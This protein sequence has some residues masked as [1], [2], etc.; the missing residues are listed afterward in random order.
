M[1]VGVLRPNQADKKRIGPPTGGPELTDFAADY[2]ACM[3]LWTMN[4]TSE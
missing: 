1:D 2:A 4:L 3:P